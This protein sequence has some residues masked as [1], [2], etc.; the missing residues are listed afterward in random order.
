M[1]DEP[2]VPSEKKDL[3]GV[4]GPDD[5]KPESLAARVVRFFVGLVL[6]VIVAMVIVYSI[7]IGRTPWDWTIADLDGFLAF[8]RQR[9]ESATD[10]VKEIDWANLKT[11][12]TEKTKSLWESAPGVEKK[13]DDRLSDVK[14]ANTRKRGVEPSVQPAQVSE[15]ATPYENGLAKMREGI[16]HYRKSPDDPAELKAAKTCFEEARAFLETA[17]KEEQDS[18]RRQEAAH[19]LDDCNK[20]LEDCR[21]REKG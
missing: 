1:T 17:L 20:Y 8:S 6:L 3:R 12:V 15:K 19:T 10:K 14:G 21:Q 16:G 2:K 18:A 11:R 13:L 9:V 5:P 4:E 7:Q